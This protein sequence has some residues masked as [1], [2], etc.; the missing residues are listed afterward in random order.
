MSRLEVSVKHNIFSKRLIFRQFYLK[1]KTN[2][3][4]NQIF[5]LEKI[6]YDLKDF[7]RMVDLKF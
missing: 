7:S 2:V 6:K 3:L 5:L 4:T 1:Y